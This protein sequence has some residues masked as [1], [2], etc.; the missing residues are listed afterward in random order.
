MVFY[1]ISNVVSPPY[2]LY[3]GFDKNENEELI[4]WGWPED[5]WFHVD[6]LSS[7]HVYLRL[8]AGE[9]IDDIPQAVIEDCV[10]LVKANSIQGNKQNNLDVVYTMWSNLKKTASMD[11]GQVGFHK[12]KD[13]KK[14]RVEKRINEIVNRLNKTKTEEQ[15][16]FRAL[17][18]DRDRK[19]RENQRRL[20]QEQKQKEKEDEKRKQE[21]AEV[22]S[23]STLMKSENMQT[24]KDFEGDDDDFM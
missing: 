6:K 15:P 9:T 14:V 23:Y 19:E 8:H 17:R 3:M 13:V 1:F 2:T 24:N 16:D 18:E 10:Q 5:V 4:R 7:A 22:R 11:V 20:Q 21:Q 12:D